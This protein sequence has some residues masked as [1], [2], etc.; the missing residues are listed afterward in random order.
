[1]PVFFEKL[2]NESEID[3]PSRQT[4]KMLPLQYSQSSVNLHLE[5]AN[6]LRA[7]IRITVGA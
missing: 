4:H 5:S 1:M 2:I 3:L 7:E 6:L